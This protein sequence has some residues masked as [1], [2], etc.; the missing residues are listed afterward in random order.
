MS[1]AAPTQD[2]DF[3]SIE[4]ISTLIGIDIEQKAMEIIQRKSPNQRRQVAK[5]VN[6]DFSIEIP[7]FQ[8]PKKKNTI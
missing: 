6:A 2:D 8:V 5:P 4:S 3:Q 1:S 7:K